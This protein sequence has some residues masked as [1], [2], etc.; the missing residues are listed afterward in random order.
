MEELQLSKIER[1]DEESVFIVEQL[2]KWVE[3]A[4]ATLNMLAM[5]EL[6]N[7]DKVEANGL[8]IRKVKRFRKIADLDSIDQKFVK[9]E[10][11]LNTQAVNE[12]IKANKTVPEGVSEELFSVGYIAE[13]K[14]VYED[15]KAR[16]VENKKKFFESRG[17]SAEA[18]EF[19]SRFNKLLKKKNEKI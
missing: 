5:R 13:P 12:Y 10:K 9:V 7:E 8:V 1:I 11:K 16:E 6:G 18:M 17:I 15:K 2:E 3:E 4:K 14:G 19:K